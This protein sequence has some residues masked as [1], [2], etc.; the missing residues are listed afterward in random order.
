ME[1]KI[2]VGR[3]GQEGVDSQLLI[4]IGANEVASII[5]KL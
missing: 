1:T 5:Q 4:T 3:Y 2:I